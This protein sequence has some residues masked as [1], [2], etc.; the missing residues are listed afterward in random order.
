VSQQA[1]EQSIASGNPVALGIPVYDNFYNAGASSYYIGLP[2]GTFYGG[3]AVFAMKYD[4]NGVWIENSWGTGWGLN[5]WAEL[6]WA[7]IDTYAYEAT[8]LGV[9]PHLTPPPTHPT[10]T[11]PPAHIYHVTVPMYLRALPR[12]SAHWGTLVRK[13]QR[14]TNAGRSTPHWTLVSIRKAHGWILKTQVR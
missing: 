13:G 10:Q 6:S 7:F 14:V 4:A 5:G 12:A 11:R 1:I 9:P 2:Q 3:H 8:A